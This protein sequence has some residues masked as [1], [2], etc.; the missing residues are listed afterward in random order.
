VTGRPAIVN[1]EAA[2]SNHD[3]RNFGLVVGSLI[4]IV[5]GLL[6][7][8]FHRRLMPWWPWPPAALLIVIALLRPG[9]LYYI[10]TIWNAV[11][12]VLGWINT[13]LILGLLFYAV[14]TPMGLLMRLL[15]RSTVRPGDA[16][17]CSSYRVESH[18][19]PQASFER[20]F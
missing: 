10:N 7:P 12:K 16:N 1:A 6:L 4:I 2:N 9:L 13:R 11:G 18:E 14:V 5:F 20:P 3:L 19:I 8:L 17:S 15:G